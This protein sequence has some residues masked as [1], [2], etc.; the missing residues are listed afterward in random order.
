MKRWISNGL[1]GTLGLMGCVLWTGCGSGGGASHGASDVR[2]VRAAESP[3]TIQL[4]W[5]PSPEQS[6]LGY[7]IRRRVAGSDTFAT[8]SD[9]LIREVAFTD[10]LPDPEDT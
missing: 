9:R 6:V 2:Y 10:Q 8:V 3:G 7:T 1:F 4:S 5:T